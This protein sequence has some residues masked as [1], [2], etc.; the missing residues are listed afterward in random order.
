MEPYTGFEMLEMLRADEMYQDST[1]I[2][3]T[4]SVMNEEVQLLK[5]SGFDGVIGKPI[6]VA[7]FPTILERV[8]AGEKIWHVTDR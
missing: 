3:L 7:N 1:I 6:N 8:V 2:A 4:A 5:S